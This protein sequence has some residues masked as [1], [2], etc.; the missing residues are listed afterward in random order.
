MALI[1]TL[2]DFDCRCTHELRFEVGLAVFEQHAHNFS[3]VDLQLVQGCRLAVCTRPPRYIAYQQT[4]FGISLDH[5][6]ERSHGIVI[7]RP[8]VTIES[9]FAGTPSVS[10]GHRF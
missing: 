5:C 8:L 2:G 7:A 10:A 3:E 6:C 4:R 1:Y 9:R